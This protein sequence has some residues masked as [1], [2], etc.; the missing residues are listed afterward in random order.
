[1]HTRFATAANL[2]T[3]TANDIDIRPLRLDPVPDVYSEDSD[4]DRDG[5][6]VGDLAEEIS[7]W[8]VN[9]HNQHAL[10]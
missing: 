9:D 6:E 2:V 10:S 8:S 4:T 5:E 1:M 3:R 7:S